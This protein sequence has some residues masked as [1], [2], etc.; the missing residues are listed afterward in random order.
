MCHT[1]QDA[2]RGG[3]QPDQALLVF[4]GVAHA[5]WIGKPDHKIILGLDH[6]RPDGNLVY[7]VERMISPT[8]DHYLNKLRLLSEL[9]DLVT[10]ER[11]N[12]K[13]MLQSM[14][15]QTVA[16]P[17]TTARNQPRV[18]PQQMGPLPPHPTGPMPIQPLPRAEE[19]HRVTTRPFTPVWTDRRIQVS[20]PTQPGDTPLDHHTPVPPLV[21]R[22]T[23]TEVK[24]ETSGLPV[25]TA[26]EDLRRWEIDHHRSRSRSPRP[27]R[28]DSP[29]S[30]RMSPIPWRQQRNQ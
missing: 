30:P 7:R 11:Q 6:V 12:Q 2:A 3:H 13:A 15:P 21:L 17:M 23:E 19:G 1:L 14:M 9:S 4:D 16:H 22:R 25:T 24:P 8:E 18:P 5:R 20:P 27:T 10:R 26:R 28:P 29:P